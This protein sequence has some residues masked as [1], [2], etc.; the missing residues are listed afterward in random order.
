MTLFKLSVSN[1]RK[2]LRDY[3]VYF[4]TL[5]IGVSVFYV[6][7][8]IGTQASYLELEND[9]R[10]IIELL[11]S[12]LSGVSVFVAIVLGLLIVYASRFLM[13]RRNREFALYLM[14][15]MGKFKISSILLI[16]T[17]IIGIC[18]LFV[19]LMI[20][21]GLS[22]IMSVFVAN[23]FEADMTE[24]QFT[25]SEEA[26]W[27]TVMYFALMYVIVMIWNT[28]V[29]SHFKLIDLMQSGKKSER[30]KLKNPWLC[31]LIFLFAVGLLSYAYYQVGWKYRDLN[32]QKITIYI[33]FGCI[34]TFLIFW[35]VSGMLLRV[36]MSMKSVYYKGLNSFTFRQISSKI[37]TMVFSMMVICLMLFVTICTLSSAFSIRNSMNA[38]IVEN[39]PADCEIYFS[40]ADEEKLAYLQSVDLE[41]IYSDS[42]KTLTENFREWVHFSTYSDENLTFGTSCGEELKTIQKNYPFLI[43]DTPEEIIGLNDYNKLMRLYGKEELSLDEGEFIVLCDFKSMA[44][45][46]NSLLQKGKTLNIFGH[47]LKSK[48]DDCQDGFVDLSSQHINAGIYVVPD[49]ILEKNYASRDYLI[50]NY[51]AENKEEKQAIEQEVCSAY[52]EVFQHWADQHPELSVLREINT[53]IDIASASVGLG[54]VITFIGM[55]IGLVFLIACGAMLALKEL[56][57]SVDSISRYEMLRRI[58]AEEKDLSKSLFQQTGIFFLLPL[59][60]ACIH[61]VFGMKFASTFLEIFGTEKMSESIFMTVS[62]LLLI[63]G[64]YFLITY[65]CSKHIIKNK[66]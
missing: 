19:G 7:N 39:C 35:S 4:F 29:I 41:K 62:I 63:Y 12:M 1:V 45:V 21:I 24:Y 17:L 61:S 18:S 15:G 66:Q 26:I 57:E 28:L 25:L 40:Y 38:T 13:K 59:I 5:V 55:Y 53:K 49:S 34:S 64:G 14:L 60:L 37:N 20:G 36:I 54:A 22:Q 8:A 3:A 43:Y 27:K 6:F 30:I 51:D 32:Q 47:E 23:L 10:N 50:G 52:E 9:T 16:E 65:F 31:V 11:K 42:G 46:R 58:G 44:E 48:Y 2:S 56:S 33:C